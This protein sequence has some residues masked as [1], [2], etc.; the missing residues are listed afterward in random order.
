MIT[1]ATNKTTALSSTCSYWATILFHLFLDEESDDIVYVSLVLRTSL[2]FFFLCV[3]D[4]VPANFSRLHFVYL[5]PL[6][7]SFVPVI[8]MGFQSMT[9]LFCI[10][11][12]LHRYCWLH[13]WIVYFSKMFKSWTFLHDTFESVSGTSFYKAQCNRFEK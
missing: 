5:F 6:I 12:S 11:V 7:R 13:V 2:N 9:Y 1:M 8:V 10:G 3:S 4:H